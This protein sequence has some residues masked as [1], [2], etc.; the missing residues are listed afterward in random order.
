MANKRILVI[1]D[2]LRSFCRS[3]LKYRVIGCLGS[4]VLVEELAPVETDEIE[5]ELE[6]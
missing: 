6:G 2:H 5:V 4:L 3:G 1:R